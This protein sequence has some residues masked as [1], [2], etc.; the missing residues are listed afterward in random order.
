[1]A[2][3]FNKAPHR[4]L[5]VSIV[6]VEVRLYRRSRTASYVSQQAPHF[7]YF[8][9]CRWTGEPQWTQDPDVQWNWWDELPPCYEIRRKWNE[10][11]RFHEALATE[12]TH[13]DKQRVR[14]KLPELPSK[15]NLDA[16]MKSIAA[17]GDVCALSKGRLDA[18]NSSHE[19]L[20]NLHNVYV[21]KYL[22]PYFSDVSAILSEAHP[23]VLCASKALRQFATS[24]PS[25]LQRRSEQAF[26][27]E[28]QS[29]MD[30][31]ARV[32]RDTWKREAQAKKVTKAEPGPPRGV[33]L[34]VIVVAPPSL[35]ESQSDGA[36]TE[37]TRR[38]APRSRRANPDDEEP[39]LRK[40]TF[41]ARPEKPKNT[42]HYKFFAQVTGESFGIN[43]R[44]VMHRMDQK[45]RRDN[46]R[47]TMLDPNVFEKES[48][49]QPSGRQMT[50][51]P[52]LARS[53]AEVLTPKAGSRMAE[54]KKK[55]KLD[56][57]K[58]RE[59]TIL[60]EQSLVNCIAAGHRPDR[61]L[62]LAIMMADICAGLR[63]IML[64][65]DAPEGQRGRRRNQ[66]VDLSH[67]DRVEGSP[68]AAL[69]VNRTYRR[70]LE[71]DMQILGKTNAD[72]EDLDD[73][74]SDDEELPEEEL[75]Q[76]RHEK[77]RMAFVEE[78]GVATELMPISWQT[79][80]QWIDRK[81]DLAEECRIKSTCQALL[82]ALKFWRQLEASV[83]QSYLGVSLNMLFQWIWPEA[84]FDNIARMLTW[85]GRHE[86]EKIRQPTPR[87]ISREDRAQLESIFG[88]LDNKKRSFITAED[89]AGGES[90]SIESQLRN[91]VDVDTVRAVYGRGPIRLLEFLE[92]ACEDN[93][94]GHDDA[95]HVQLEDGRRLVFVARQV[96]GCRGW[97]LQDAPQSE[98]TQRSLVEAL[99]IE[100]DRWKSIGQ[101]PGKVLEGCSI[102]EPTEYLPAVSKY[103]RRSLGTSARLAGGLIGGTVV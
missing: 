41:L 10:I 96:T 90:S 68:E 88:M 59:T 50:L 31:A 16:F 35:G 79:V 73:A 3:D 65:E 92:I 20:S 52:T 98:E 55:D 17:T 60:S 14:T 9:R 66:P 11:V 22:A 83:A 69:I 1:M 49:N 91:I 6:R 4:V 42:S 86:F 36:L 48:V 102:L 71:E 21:E 72:V 54:P 44:E 87:V 75:R 15:G 12:L 37:A 19:D 85:I 62:R 82:R 32:L 67:Y 18:E 81:S 29:A 100:V 8:L 45:E 84:R 28:N 51:R 63:T 13:N 78:L 80:F 95:S 43:D 93:F 7:E 76:R 34:P 94:R 53:T 24:G 97:L 99:E 2:V 70:L 61:N 89:L 46:A 38:G 57:K 101:I 74:Q 39:S 47:K 26:D 103:N 58:H 56:N 27:L 64:G 40:L 30:A 77:E 25:S 5:S 33:S 23:D